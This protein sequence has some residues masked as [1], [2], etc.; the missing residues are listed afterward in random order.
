[1]TCLANPRV[2][3]GRSR[4]E[5]AQ[6]WGIHKRVVCV[7]MEMPFKIV[8]RRQAGMGDYGGDRRRGGGGGEREGR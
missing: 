1:M 7:L 4:T 3:T 2:K 6:P 8:C 5:S